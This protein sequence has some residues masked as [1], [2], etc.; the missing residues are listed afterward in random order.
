MIKKKAIAKKKG[1]RPPGRKNNATLMKEAEIAKCLKL[2]EG[3]AASHAADIVLAM[4]KKAKQGDVS[5]AKL[6][7]DRVYPARRQVD[8]DSG[9][10][11]G[12]TI[13][14][15]S[16]DHGNDQRQGEAGEQPDVQAHGQESFHHE[17]VEVIALHAGKEGQR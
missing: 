3:H 11:Q 7:L 10:V 9:G 6:I 5:A 15:R 2:C 12:I 8:S 13:N 1:G 16:T 17:G 14:I 4:V